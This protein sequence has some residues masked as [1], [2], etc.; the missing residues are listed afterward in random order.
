MSDAG[1]KFSVS[2]CHHA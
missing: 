1:L 2:L